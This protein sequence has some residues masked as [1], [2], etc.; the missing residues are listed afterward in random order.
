MSDLPA[1][2]EGPAET[3][4]LRPTLESLPAYVA[5]KPAA[6]DGIRRYK[7]SSNESHLPPIPAVR[8]AAIEKHGAIEGGQQTL[9]NLA[10]HAAALVR[11]GRRR[12]SATAADRRATLKACDLSP[13]P[14]RS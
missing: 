13:E 7:V 1:R 4:R 5:G 10:D 9:A 8:D 12:P 11:T 14:N 3:I 2:S 6:D